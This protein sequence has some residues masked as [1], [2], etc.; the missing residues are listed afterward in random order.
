MPFLNGVTLRIGPPSSL[1]LPGVVC[2]RPQNRI[3]IGKRLA[4]HH[5]VKCPGKRIHHRFVVRRRVW[6]GPEAAVLLLGNTR[7]APLL[8]QAV[9]ETC[10]GFQF[11]RKPPATL[12]IFIHQG[13]D[14]RSL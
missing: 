8:M 6:I 13:T 1:D 14:A 10:C 5:C 9:E 7:K 3:M 11:S 4:I 2:G 12:A